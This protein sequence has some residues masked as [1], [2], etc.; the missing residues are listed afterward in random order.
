MIIK[1]DSDLCEIHQLLMG[2]IHFHAHGPKR[3]GLTT[4]PADG[5]TV[6]MLRIF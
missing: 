1:R 2:N 5:A 6:I 3:L 4:G